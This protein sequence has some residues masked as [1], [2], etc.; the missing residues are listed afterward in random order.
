V[1]NL[2]TSEQFKNKNGLPLNM[3][4]MTSE[5]TLPRPWDC[6]EETV[7]RDQEIQRFQKKLDQAK[8]IL[9]K[10]RASIGKSQ[11]A[12]SLVGAYA[13]ERIIWLDCARVFDGLDSALWEIARMTQDKDLMHF[14]EVD[15]YVHYPGSLKLGCLFYQLVHLEGEHVI[16]F[17]NVH[18]W[19]DDQ[20]L[21]TL[22]MDLKAHIQHGQAQHLRLVAL[23][24][25]VLHFWQEPIFEFLSGVSTSEALQQIM[26]V[27]GFGMAPALAA[28]VWQVT[29]GHPGQALVIAASADG[30]EAFGELA[31]AS[32]GQFAQF[33]HQNQTIANRLADSYDDLS[34]E[35]RLVL[36]A[37]AVF[38]EPASPDMIKQVLL[39]EDIR[40]VQAY[41]RSLI[42]K[43]LLQKVGPF[44]AE[45]VISPLDRA[46]YLS[47]ADWEVLGRLNR[48]AARYY[49]LRED[50]ELA[51]YHY[52]EAER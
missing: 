12:A 9:L 13:P 1:E 50:A 20:A 31:S 33:V 36:Q 49:E 2:T 27:H 46:F 17:D 28:R 4:D 16:C 19:R 5:C 11:I 42:N 41:R 35:A 34:Y 25:E 48:R 40:N 7:G 18:A 8:A 47:E 37:V 3:A 30:Y 43:F 44:S 6:F 51:A 39:G 15:S 24:R 29:Q 32:E 26:S 21:V 52:K 45:V 38:T 23:T 14:L 10:G 22:V